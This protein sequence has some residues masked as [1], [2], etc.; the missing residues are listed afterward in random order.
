MGSSIGTFIGA[1]DAFGP[2]NDGVIGP[3]IGPAIGLGIGACICLGGWGTIILHLGF[4]YCGGII[5]GCGY[6]WGGGTGCT[7]DYTVCAGWVVVWVII[8]A[9]G[10]T[11]SI[12][13]W[14]L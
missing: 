9:V 7:I 5:G 6:I 8:V 13:V 11:T 12:C 3:G 14:I 10:W 4:K 1:V 2:P